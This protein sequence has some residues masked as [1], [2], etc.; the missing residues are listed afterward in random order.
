MPITRTL[1]M[2]FLLAVVLWPTV[3]SAATYFVD[4]R[5]ATTG[6]DAAGTQDKPFAA[7]SQ[8]VDRLRPGDTLLIRAGLYRESVTVTR[9]GTPEQPIVISAA[10]GD[11]GKVI[12]TGSDAIRGWRHEVSTEWSVP[13]AQRLD[14]K[15]PADW[16]DCGEYPRRCE[17][18][19]VRGQPLTQVL[20]EGL[21]R[22]GTFCVS[23]KKGRLFIAL[24]EFG[25]PGPVE[26]AVRQRGLY[27][28]A[29]NVRL[30][31]LTVTH[32]AS[33]YPE[34]ALHVWGNDVEVR[35]CR[36]EWNNLDGLRLAV[37]RCRVIDSVFDNNGKCGIAASMSRTLLEG[38]TTN[39]N[40]WRYGPEC[41]AGGVKICGGAPF[42]NRII[43]HTA[44]D[45]NG[46]GIWFDYGCKDNRIERCVVDNNLISGI[47]MEAC[48]PDNWIINCVVTRTR[49]WKDSINEHGTGA[50]IMLYESAGTHVLNNT[51]VGNELCGL[52]IAGGSRQIHY[53]KSEAASI[54]TQVLNNI[55]AGSANAAIQFWVW[56]KSATKESLASHRSDYNLFFPPEK[57]NVAQVPPGKKLPALADWQKAFS[58]DAH[59]VQADPR[60]VNPTKG[61]YRLSDQSPAAGAGTPIDDV[62]KDCAGVE[63][64]K[65]K[66]SIGAYERAGS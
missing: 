46:R 20:A 43:A 2:V 39:S 24:R 27:V 49:V 13:W 17:M 50:G 44:R 11:E 5:R 31:G 14:A 25:D 8:A 26:V 62:A 38:N 54:N 61:D 9:S 23:E 41:E 59:S 35:N 48:Q 40:S 52:M 10:P 21:L 63:R 15:F 6:P 65:D 66:P 55:F 29:S 47:E 18:V 33:P 45:N 28:H 12:I 37:G 57:G 53:D 22:R 1:H 32:V 60:F 30:N 64:P 3:A 19:F 34:G 4:A 56:D 36:A 51:I 7:I 16:G 58:Q 42:G